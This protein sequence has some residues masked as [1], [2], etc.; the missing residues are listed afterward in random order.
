MTTHF[1]RVR[2]MYRCL[3][4]LFWG[5]SGMKQDWQL[6]DTR[7]L[8]ISVGV[9]NPEDLRS[10][11][12]YLGTLRYGVV[13]FGA[14]LQGPAS[15]PNR[16]EQVRCCWSAVGVLA[17]A[18]HQS[19]CRPVHCRPSH[20]GQA[21]QFRPSN[22]GRPIQAIQSSSTPWPAPPPTTL[23]SSSTGRASTDPDGP[24]T[25]RRLGRLEAQQRPR[26]PPPLQLQSRVVTPASI[27]NRPRFSPS[28]RAARS[29]CQ[30][31]SPVGCPSV[32]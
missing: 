18:L 3:G 19:G 14:G 15:L 26:L 25:P 20:A 9:S 8:S 5:A 11:I 24:P 29:P 23:P 2:S 4:E 10:N 7:L 21:I 6:L 31:A 30:P 16:G 32:P 12:R 1:V 22:P 27:E 28:S 17:L 13:G